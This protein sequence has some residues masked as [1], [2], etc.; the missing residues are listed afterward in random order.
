MSETPI[1]PVGDPQISVTTVGPADARARVE[2]YAERPVI[3]LD[4]GSLGCESCGNKRF[5]RSRVRFGDMREL[6]MN[7]LPVRCMRCGQRQYHEAPFAFL[8]SS[9]KTQIVRV[10]EGTD[11]WRSWTGTATEDGSRPM[12]TVMGTR[13][14]RLTKPE[15][16]PSAQA[17]PVETQRAPAMPVAT[18]PVRIPRRKS[19]DDG[20]W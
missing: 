20:I 2:P 13:A 11:T 9:V 5:R 12:T 4:K 15:Q 19:G 17:Q 16:E 14:Q 7:R 6:M 18:P 10:S 1:P 8:A 3:K